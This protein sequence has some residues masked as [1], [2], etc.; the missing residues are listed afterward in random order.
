M[1][2]FADSMVSWTNLLPKTIAFSTTEAEIIAGS[3]GAKEF[4]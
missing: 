4:V 2:I 3:E 1:A